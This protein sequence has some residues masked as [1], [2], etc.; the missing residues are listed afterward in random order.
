MHKSAL[1]ILFMLAFGI[2]AYAG[3]E[4]L[5][6]S[7][8]EMKETIAPAP[9]ACDFTWAGFYIGG[10]GGGAWGDGHTR[11]VP[12]PSAPGFFSGALEPTSL[13]ADISGGFGG[14]QLGF[15]WQIGRFVLG[16]ET[17]IEGSDINGDKIRRP[18]PVA[19]PPPLPDTTFLGTSED[20]NW[21]G[22]VRGRIGFAP[23]CHLLIYGTGGLAYGN[24]GY[25]GIVN[26]T[27]AGGPLIATSVNN[28]NVGWTAGG[29]LEIAISRHWTIKAEYLYVDLGDE[30]STVLSPPGFGGRG[31]EA[32]RFHWDTNTQTVKGG[33]NFKF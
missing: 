8:K 30:S 22:T 29:G 17:D 31:N 32:V 14:G 18:V 16:A 5:P 25:S 12:E 7:G 24:A 10:N 27:S 11:F 1:T 4:S 19:L 3:P 26:Y 9:P 21:F 33:L 15:N 20:I 13:D 6:S 28:T 23:L 2:F